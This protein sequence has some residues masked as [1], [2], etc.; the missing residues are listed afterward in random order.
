[1]RVILA[2]ADAAA[3]AGWK[4]ELA[5]LGV[6]SADVAEVTDVRSLLQTITDGA[7]VSLVIT[8]WWLSGTNGFSLLGEIKQR[9]RGAPTPVL[10]V[11]DPADR[12]PMEA[13]LKAGL[14]AY[15]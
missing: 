8:S 9:R 7:D 6:A 13:C 11:G 12:T 5:E 3:R 2:E 4:A 14:T 10:A 15:V 1:M